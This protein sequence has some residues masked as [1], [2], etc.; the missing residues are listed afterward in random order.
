MLGEAEILLASNKTLSYIIARRKVVIGTLHYSLGLSHPT[1]DL[2]RHTR[3]AESENFT[4]GL[5]TNGFERNQKAR[6]TV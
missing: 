6:Q 3:G 1:R 4:T 2:L 5:Q